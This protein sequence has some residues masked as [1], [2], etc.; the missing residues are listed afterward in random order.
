MFQGVGCG[1]NDLYPGILNQPETIITDK[2]DN[3]IAVIDSITDHYGARE[4]RVSVPVV[5]KINKDGTTLWTKT[6][7]SDNGLGWITRAST[8]NDNNIIIAHQPGSLNVVLKFDPSGNTL[9]KT[10][11]PSDIIGF[12]RMREI[13]VDNENNIYIIGDSKSPKWVALVRLS[14]DGEVLGKK[15]YNGLGSEYYGNSIRYVSDKKL[16]LLTTKFS[17]FEAAVLYMSNGFGLL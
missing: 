13:T 2:Q 1:A 15:L 11:L 14:P 5:N 17:P 6:L 8:D 9:W 4:T 12:E 10:T 3:Y 16:V 7:D